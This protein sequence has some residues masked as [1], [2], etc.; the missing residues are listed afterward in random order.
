MDC[1][2]DAL[3]VSVTQIGRRRVGAVPT[4][5]FTHD[6]SSIV[7]LGAGES[8]PPWL[9]DQYKAMNAYIWTLPEFDADKYRQAAVHSS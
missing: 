1:R 4:H 9:A 2:S 7:Q 5:S 8:S 3:N 6:G